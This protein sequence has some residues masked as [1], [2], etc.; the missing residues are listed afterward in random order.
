MVGSKLLYPH[1]RV[2]ICDVQIVPHGSVV[3]GV[4]IFAVFM[5]HFLLCSNYFFNIFPFI[6][7]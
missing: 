3:V 6:T 5:S 2:N 4:L 7:H 1:I